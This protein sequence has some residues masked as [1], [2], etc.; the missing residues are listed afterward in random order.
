MLIKEVIFDRSYMVIEK[1]KNI[2]VGL[3]THYV[4]VC[5]LESF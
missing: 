2:L 3:F 4:I 5:I 1:K